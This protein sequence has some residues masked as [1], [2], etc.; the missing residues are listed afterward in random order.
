VTHLYLEQS[1]II[2][3]SIGVA[4]GVAVIVSTVG[5]MLLR[6][7]RLKLKENAKQSY[8]DILEMLET[9][10]GSPHRQAAFNSG[11]YRVI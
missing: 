8:E 6:K 1:S 3:I 9:E 7:R 5:Y 2:P 10:K 11:I 4:I